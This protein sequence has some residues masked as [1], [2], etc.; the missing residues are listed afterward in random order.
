MSMGS[1]VNLCSAWLDIVCAQKDCRQSHTGGDGAL[2]EE[3]DHGLTALLEY[4]GC[5]HREVGSGVIGVRRPWR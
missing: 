4:L 3:A 2:A 1:V 5:V